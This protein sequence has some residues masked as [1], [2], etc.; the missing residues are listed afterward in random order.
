MEL[1]LNQSVYQL[2]ALEIIKVV[3]KY[4][5]QKHF[6]VDEKFMGLVIGLFF[7]LVYK[8]LSEWIIKLSFFKVNLE[9]ILKGFEE[10]P[11][12]QLL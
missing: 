4:S 10:Q 6:M 9:K 2:R 7:L 5:Y 12:L 8:L 1:V 3:E 11:E